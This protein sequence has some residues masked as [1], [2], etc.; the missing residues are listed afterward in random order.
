MSGELQVPDEVQAKFDELFGPGPSQETEQA[1]GD[2]PTGPTSRDRQR[3]EEEAE[4]LDGL[5]GATD[6]DL[7]GEKFGEDQLEGEG[8]KGQ[9]D[10]SQSQGK[11]GDA[12]DQS[13]KKDSTLPA[14]LS[15]AAK[16]AGW[17]DH[18]IEDLYQ[19]DPDLAIRTFE[20]L[21]DSYSEMGARFR[22]IGQM[23]AIQGQQQQTSPTQPQQQQPAAKGS[24]LDSFLQNRYGDRL[25]QF[26]ERFGEGFVD[27]VLKPL[28][29]PVHRI[30]NQYAQQERQAIGAEVNTFFKGLAGEFS[31]LYG[32][33]ASKVTGEQDAARQEVGQ[34]ADWIREGASRSNGIQLSVSEALDMAV[35]NHSAPQ[36]ALLERKRLTASL[37]KRASKMTSRPTQRAA[38]PDPSDQPK[39]IEAAMSAYSERAGQLGF[40]TRGTGA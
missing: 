8:A 13:Q 24:D 30:E 26:N 15:H 22:Q 23:A 19:K 20:K 31:E 14:Y 17:E 38:A 12:K 35:A 4:E 27:D 16:R 28:A 6:E 9:K 29:E 11:E 37:Q 1:T 10:A 21:H 39:T 25:G 32:S 2:R 36:I 40:D 34:M 5:E 18:H 33:D 3:D 7:K